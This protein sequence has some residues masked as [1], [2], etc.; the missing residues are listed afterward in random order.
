MGR[1]GDKYDEFLSSSILMIFLLLLLTFSQHPVSAYRI[2]NNGPILMFKVSKWTCQS[3]Q[4]DKIICR[5]CHCLLLAK[6][7][8]KENCSIIEILKHNFTE[9]EMTIGVFLI[10]CLK[11]MHKKLQVYW[12]K[13][14]GVMVIFA[15]FAMMAIL[16]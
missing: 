15:I 8:T 1:V 10:F 12:T 13:I 16:V 14:G 4:H 5:Q 6:N 2:W 11:I 7:G 9:A 3:A